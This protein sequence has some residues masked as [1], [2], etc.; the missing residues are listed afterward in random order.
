MEKFP[1]LVAAEFRELDWGLGLDNKE[2]FKEK[3]FNG[4]LFSFIGKN[5]P[6]K[7]KG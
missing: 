2:N 6:R 1:L 5:F 7:H 3:C 4:L